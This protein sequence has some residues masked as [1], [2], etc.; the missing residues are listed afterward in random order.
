[1]LKIEVITKS[2]KMIFI[3]YNYNT[4]I[5]SFRLSIA[6][7]LKL[8]KMT[9]DWI[10]IFF[11]SMKVCFSSNFGQGFCLVDFSSVEIGIVP[12]DMTKKIRNKIS[13]RIGSKRLVT[14]S[15][16]YYNNKLEHTIYKFACS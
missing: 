5:F 16:C 12:Y 2:G 7:S 15:S 13:S 3:E 4:N 1:M 11:T 14:V 9:N 6:L 10:Y 8:D